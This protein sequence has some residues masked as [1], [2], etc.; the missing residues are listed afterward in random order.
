[1]KEMGIAREPQLWDEASGRMAGEGSYEDYYR[2]LAHGLYD[3]I[4]QGQ[5]GYTPQEQADIVGRD[6]LDQ[7]QLTPGESAAID[8]QPWEQTKIRGDLDAE[9][10]YF[11]PA[12]QSDIEANAARNRRGALSTMDEQMAGA[13]GKGLYGSSGYYDA[14]AGNLRGLEKGYEE[15]IDPTKLGLDPNFRARY[16]MTPEQVQRIETA[17]GT[18]VGNRN[19]ADMSQIQRAATASGSGWRGIPALGQ[20]MRREGAI[21]AAD[22]MTNARIAA[23]AEAANRLKTLE[24]MRRTGELDIAGMKYGA[25]GSLADLGFGT[26]QAAEQTRMAGEQDVANRLA[27]KA[28]TVGLAKEASEAGIGASEQATA[29]D[30]RDFGSEQQRYIEAERQRREQQL[31]DERRANELYRQ[32]QRYDRGIYRDTALS[33]RTADVAGA[34]RTDEAEARGWATGEEAQAANRYG[35]AADRR[36]QGFGT[37]AGTVGNAVNARTNWANRGKAWHQL[38]PSGNAILG[39][40]TGRWGK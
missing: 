36:I 32:G 11:N 16:E 29:R 12:L 1:M 7:L 31:A 26:A 20:R 34:R 14:L 4:L 30:V 27:E 15:A 35:T 40:A 28:R 37:A 24:E 10:A 13:I 19:L 2:R 22:A 5:G 17:A 39:A 9:R 21:G 8:Y 18:D 25:A 33:G 3:P 23:E 38:V 6:R